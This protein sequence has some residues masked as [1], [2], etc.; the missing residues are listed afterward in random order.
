MGAITEY[1]QDSFAKFCPQGWTCRREVQVLDSVLAELFG[2][3][4]KADVSLERNDGQRKL[5]IEFEVSR[6]DPVA[7]HA[8]FA[9]AHLFQPQLPTETFVSMVSW[10]V[11]RGKRNLGANTISLMRYIGMSAFQTTLFPNIAP[12]E[13]KRLNHLD[14]Q[15]LAGSNLEP[16]REIARALEVSEPLVT[17]KEHRVYFVGDLLDVICNLRSWNGSV[18][19]EGGRSLWGRRRVQYFVFDRKTQLFAPSKFCAYHPISLHHA[20]APP[21]STPMMTMELYASLDE[22]DPRFDGNRARRHLRDHLGMTLQPLLGNPELSVLFEVWLQGV[23]E[24]VQVDGR[25]AQVLCP[26]KWLD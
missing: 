22:G 15:T 20:S 12:E 7:N 24:A 8:K 6:A 5:W 10:H 21:I 11:A 4:P 23:G 19:T 3:A 26:P 1:L 2:Y 14:K 18:L 17:T 9:T 16:S 25:G 13:I